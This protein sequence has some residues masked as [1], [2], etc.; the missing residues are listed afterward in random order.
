MF[1]KGPPFTNKFE[2]A[3]VEMEKKKHQ[4][5]DL[6]KVCNNYLIF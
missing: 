1:G 5:Y 2:N 6:L 3:C 4:V